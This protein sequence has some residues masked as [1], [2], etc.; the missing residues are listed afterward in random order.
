M[1]DLSPP[2]VEDRTALVLELKQ[3]LPVRRVTGAR[4]QV[5]RAA[6]AV[7]AVTRTTGALAPDAPYEV[8]FGDPGR[9]LALL[10]AAEDGDPR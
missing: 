3:G 7:A 2:R 9:L 4:H 1:I 6:E 5:Q 8:L 10:G